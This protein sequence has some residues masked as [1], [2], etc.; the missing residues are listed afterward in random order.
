M[1]RRILTVLALPLLSL[2]Q[3]AAT[4]ES[5]EAAKYSNLELARIKAVHE[6]S[7]RLENYVLSGADIEESKL[8]FGAESNED[9]DRLLYFRLRPL[10]WN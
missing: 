3:H 6:L 8:P 4:E 9:C 10:A 1:N 5:S 2:N 7:T